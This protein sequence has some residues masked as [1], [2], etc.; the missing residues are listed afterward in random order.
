MFVQERRHQSI[1]TSTS[2][3]VSCTEDLWLTHLR[4]KSRVKLQTV[5]GGLTAGCSAVQR[6]TKKE[7][8]H[9]LLQTLHKVENSPFFLILINTLIGHFNLCL[10]I[11]WKIRLL[12]VLSRRRLAWVD[13][14]RIGW[15]KECAWCGTRI[16]IIFCKQRGLNVRW[17]KLKPLA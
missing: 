3:D 6:P 10:R 2:R 12:N 1:R 11:R 15:Q 9:S 7:S 5:L 16:L 14:Q 4:G 13:S 17:K 8:N